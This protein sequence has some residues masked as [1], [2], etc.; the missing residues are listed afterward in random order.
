MPI[1]PSDE[2]EK[3]F[4][5]REARRREELRRE[6][7]A[8]AAKLAQRERTARAAGTEDMSLVERLHELGFDGDSVRVLDLV[9]LVLVAWAD[10]SVSARERATVMDAVAQRGIE[11]DSRPWLLIASMLEQRPSDGL[12]REIMQVLGELVGPADARGRSIVELSAKVA[13][14]SRGLFGLGSRIDA[15]ERAVIADIAARFAPG[16]RGEIEGKLR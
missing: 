3:Y 16:A 12:V 10:G 11:P 15:A 14:A 8:A 4:H 2:E 5:Q 7:E 9:P 6:M 1:K 13:E